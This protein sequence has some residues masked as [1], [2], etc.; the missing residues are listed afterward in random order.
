MMGLIRW[1]IALAATLSLFPLQAAI[2]SSAIDGI[3]IRSGV[4]Q[5][6]FRSD[7]Y[8]VH[9]PVGQLEVT[10]PGASAS[11]PQMAEGEVIYSNPWPGIRLG[12]DTEHG[13]IRSTFVVGAGAKPDR[14]RMEYAAPATIGRDGSLRIYTESG[15]FT[16][17]P[18]IAWQEGGQGRE[19]VDV[20]FRAIDANTIGFNLGDY[21]RSRPLIIDPTLDWFNFLGSDG[22]VIRNEINAVTVDAN[23]DY[24]VTGFAEDDWTETVVAGGGDGSPKSAHAGAWDVYVAKLKSSGGVLWH[25]FLGGSSY[26]VGNDL[27]IADGKLFVTGY[28]QS[29][30]WSDGGS[31][32]GNLGGVADAFVAELDPSSGQ[33]SAMHYIG[34][35]DDDEAY[36][37]TANGTTLYIT[38]RSKGDDWTAPNQRTNHSGDGSEDLFIARMNTSGSI[39]WYAFYGDKG[40]DWGTDVATD[41]SGFVYVSGF[42]TNAW[43]AGDMP[44][45]RGYTAADVGT[46]EAM[47]LKFDSTGTLQWYGFLG[48]EG[49][50]QTSSHGSIAV[51]GDTLYVTGKSEG[52]D[53]GELAGEPVRVHGGGEDMFVAS[54]QTSD[55]GLRWYTFLGGAAD[56]EGTG[57]FVDDVG[58][59]RVIGNSR[60]SW[61]P[62]DDYWHYGAYADYAAAYLDAED[63][64]LLN[65]WFMGWLFRDSF[66]NNRDYFDFATG[67]VKDSVG[68]G[69][70]VV[71]TSGA[72]LSGEQ[73]W[74]G[75]AVHFGPEGQL[76]LYGNNLLIGDADFEPTAD[77]GTDFGVV[78]VGVGGVVHNFTLRNIGAGEVTLANPEDQD[79]PYVYFQRTGR[80]IS[81]FSLQWPAADK[82]TP[83]ILSPGEKIDFSVTFEPN[84]VSAI[85]QEPYFFIK[86]D[87]GDG[88]YSL[89][90]IGATTSAPQINVYGP[91]KVLGSGWRIITDGD[92]TPSS[93]DGTLFG[94]VAYDAST[95]PS[96]TFQILNSGSEILQ[97]D[98]SPTVSLSNTVDFSVTSQPGSSLSTGGA[99]EFTVQFN[100]EKPGVKETTVSIPWNDSAIPSRSPRTF[101]IRGV[102]TGPDIA[103]T[104]NNV[105]IVD[106]DDTPSLVDHTSFS[107][108]TVNDTFKRT[109]VINNLGQDALDVTGITIN[110][111]NGAAFA[112]D[113]AFVPFSVAANG[114][115]V[116]FDVAFTP[117]ASTNY[118]AKVTVSNNDPD[119]EGEY[120]FNISG[121]G[122]AP[123][124]GVRTDAQAIADGG[125]VEVGAEAGE[126]TTITFY[127]ENSAVGANLSLTGSPMIALSNTADFSIVT[128]PESST[129]AG[130]YS[131]SSPVNSET[132][133][134]RYTAPADGRSVSTTVSIANNDANENPYDFTLFGSTPALTLDKTKVTVTERDEDN[135]SY[136][137]LTVAASS[138]PSGDVVLEFFSSDPGEVLLWNGKGLVED[139]KASATVTIAGGA[140]APATA[141]LWVRGVD[142]NVL[143]LDQTVRITS[144]KPSSSDATY[145]SESMRL[146][147]ISV[148]NRNRQYSSSC[149]GYATLPILSVLSG[150]TRICKYAGIMTITGLNVASNGEIGLYAN[151]VQGGDPTTFANGSRVHVS[152]DMS[153]LDEEI[154][155]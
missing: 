48:G 84:T 112:L 124:I 106:G 138:S 10:F 101:T 127:I 151:K 114:Q 82:K 21:D 9:G 85:P 116:T 52:P 68:N 36:G 109:F 121:S 119:E 22:G 58:N 144:N 113:G 74:D 14:I 69:F 6:H 11:K 125:S 129:V 105:D 155:D 145:N 103:I 147:T 43:A 118:S 136:Q 90:M 67:L 72:T 123:E 94:S 63:G 128:Y 54:L 98:G 16:E 17:S 77:D 97:L 5:I 143:D 41:G 53:W 7:G 33:L 49:N 75:A 28:T 135:G 122:G 149:S 70:L 108:V 104:G 91:D 87:A 62:S 8:G 88:T 30:A 15:G 1:G 142:D 100:P 154:T 29:E 107:V 95:N 126:S 81:G 146:P 3:S 45:A 35:T 55:G 133:E 24:Y 47:V 39:A 86:S 64:T 66:G 20:A 131:I 110:N 18:P 2:D 37:I 50:D 111:I 132:F 148:V 73:R 27:V 19:P 78:G 57:L 117:T 152:T 26:E 76:A 120:T 40:I 96:E 56:D 99:T 102:G 139:Y 130:R 79:Y 141:E 153:V 13:I 32:S 34:G 134:V 71:G 25:T 59:L 4:H 60:A 137:V 46:R 44:P 23:G 51:S 150:H 92:V 65:N 61:G 93:D 42:S 31:T 89:G 38:G 140:P 12:Y 83:L 115:P 80:D